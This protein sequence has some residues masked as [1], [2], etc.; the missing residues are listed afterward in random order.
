MDVELIRKID[1]ILHR[2]DRVLEHGRESAF[3][4]II[5]LE[6]E[7]LTLD[8]IGLDV[9]KAIKRHNLIPPLAVCTFTFRTFLVELK[10]LLLF[11]FDT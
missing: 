9:V 11:L 10:S 3:A 2:G 7:D 6:W 5:I 1:Q 4:Q 8:G